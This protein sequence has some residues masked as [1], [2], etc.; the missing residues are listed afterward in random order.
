MARKRMFDLDVINQDSFY[1]LPMEAKAIYFLLGMEADDEGFINPKKI[2][3][4][5]GGNE[6]SVKILILKNYIIPFKSGVV[7]LIIA[8]IRA[9]ILTKEVL[10]AIILRALFSCL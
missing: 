6:D 1:D 4:L 2:L 10:I 9:N 7:Y 3:R 8:T 5:Y